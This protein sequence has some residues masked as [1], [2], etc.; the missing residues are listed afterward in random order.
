MCS[1]QCKAGIS[2]CYIYYIK[3][4]Q[5]SRKEANATLG[6]FH[7]TY[8]MKQRTPLSVSRETA[9]VSP[10]GR[11]AFFH[12]WYDCVAHSLEV[13]PA[14][15]SFFLSELVEREKSLP[16]QRLQDHWMFH[17]CA[18]HGFVPFKFSFQPIIKFLLNGKY[19][20]PSHITFVYSLKKHDAH[21]Y[22]VCFLWCLAFFLSLS[23][24]MG[25][26]LHGNHGK[27]LSG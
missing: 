7:S 23:V 6:D 26:E 11:E 15:V 17:D 24:W 10:L 13:I 9:A 20:F 1:A 5:S 2:S 12:W 16:M 19:K 21:F 3:L 4:H 25:S 8:N 22:S 18:A 14:K 27:R